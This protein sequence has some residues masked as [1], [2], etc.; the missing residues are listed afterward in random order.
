M[1]QRILVTGGKGQLASC[2][3]AIADQYP[4]LNFIFVDRTIMDISNDQH[5]SE[6]FG[7]NKIDWC[8]NC[9]AYTTVDK[10]ESEDDIANEV[11]VLGPKNLAKSCKEHDVKLVHISTDFVFNG[12]KNRAYTENDATG[13]LNT[14]GKTKLQ[15]EQEVISVLDQHFIIRTSW[16]YSEFGHNFMRTML[17][18]SKEKEQLQIVNDQIGTPTYA[19]DLATFIVQ[20]IATSSREFGLY[21]YSNEGVASW[22]DFAKAIFDMS[23]ID[24]KVNP[25]AS[26]N[27]PTAANRPTFSVLDNAKIKQT[28]NSEPKYWRES[29]EVCLQNL[30]D[31]HYNLNPKNQV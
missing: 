29:L 5:V 31:D 24:I 15:G 6:F 2:I 18:L 14:Y 11:N 8:I 20:L 26:D 19:G 16:L 4:N 30:K 25:I 21:N 1:R 7:K 27:F 17:K 13:P 28:F 23:K 9:A 12:E 22:Y 10:A 3:H